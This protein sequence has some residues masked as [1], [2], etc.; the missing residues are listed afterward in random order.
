M[1]QAIKRKYIMY[2]FRAKFR[3]EDKKA[4]ILGC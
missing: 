1:T 2:K 4:N 3:S